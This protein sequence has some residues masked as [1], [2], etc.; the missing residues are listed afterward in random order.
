MDFGGRG[1]WY[2]LCGI[3]MVNREHGSMSEE[4]RML[5]SIF[6]HFFVTIALRKHERYQ[7]ATERK[8]T[9]TRDCY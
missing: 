9:T 4:S 7:K 1:W 2:E 6:I 8:T 3:N 5:S